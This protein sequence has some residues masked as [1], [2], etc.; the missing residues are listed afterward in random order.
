MT[1]AQIAAFQKAEVDKWAAGHQGGEHQGRVA[2]APALRQSASAK[3]GSV[4]R[5]APPAFLEPHLVRSPRRPAPVPA[6]QAGADLVRRLGRGQGARRGH[7]LDHPALRRASTASNMGEALDSDI[8]QL[9]ELQRVLHARAQARRA[10][11]GRRRPGVAR[12][13]APSASSAPSTATRS[14]RPRATATRPPRWSAATPRWPRSSRTA[15]SPRS[16]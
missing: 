3:R 2:V 5:I 12:S 11:A 8:A 16:T 9:H 7:D 13:T 14:S 4:D 15:A 1:T 6:A 10:A